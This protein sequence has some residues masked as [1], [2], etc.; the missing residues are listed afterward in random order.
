M[1]S[2]L[3]PSFSWIFSH[4]PLNSD[5]L[6]ESNLNNTS[7]ETSLE[8]WASLVAQ[9][10][11][12]PLAMRKT[13]VQSLDRE[14]PLEKEMAT[15]SRTLCWK[16]PRTEEPGRLQSM[17]SQS[18]RHNWTQSTVLWQKYYNFHFVRSKNKVQRS[19]E[20]SSRSHSWDWATL[21]LKPG[22][23]WC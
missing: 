20:T 22:S 13:W 17:V 19:Q 10:V 4:F 3:L 7:L 5:V 8:I 23:E 14:D 6:S 1:H 11:K 12:N 18:V 15:L 16:I 2:F 9:L 21:R